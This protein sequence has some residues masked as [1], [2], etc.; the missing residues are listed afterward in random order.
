MASDLEKTEARVLSHVA[1][2]TTYTYNK[3]R[4]FPVEA[5]T[6]AANV[7]VYFGGGDHYRTGIQT[8]AMAVAVE[9]WEYRWKEPFPWDLAQFMVLH[10]TCQVLVE[11][12]VEP[13]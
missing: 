4:R 11:V 3:N 7:L 12:R 9:Q 5:G 2:I 10:V 8:R 6:R 13:R 1:E